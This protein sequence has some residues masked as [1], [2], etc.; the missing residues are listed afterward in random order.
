MRPYF[1]GD[2]G[3]NLPLQIANKAAVYILTFFACSVD[4]GFSSVLEPGNCYVIANTN[5][6]LRN[7]D[8]NALA[9]EPSVEHR[10]TETKTKPRRCLYFIKHHLSV[11]F[12]SKNTC[13]LILDVMD[14]EEAIPDVRVK[15]FLQRSKCFR[16]QNYDS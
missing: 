6:S 16:W 15:I 1:L 2:W 10:P 7:V 8:A 9:K 4:T 5:K 11:F 14:F 13:N 12:Q 3:Q